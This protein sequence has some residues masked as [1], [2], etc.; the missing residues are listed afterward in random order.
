[1][2]C[3]AKMSTENLMEMMRRSEKTKRKKE[4]NE[5]ALRCEC[6]HKTNH[7]KKDCW[8][9]NPLLKP[10]N[11]GRRTGT[12]APKNFK[13]RTCYACG[14]PGHVAKYCRSKKIG[15]GNSAFFGFATIEETNVQ[16]EEYVDSGATKHIAPQV[17]DFVPGSLKKVDS[18]GVRQADG[19][20]L[21]AT[22]VGTRTI[23]HKDGR[24]LTLKEVYLVP[25]LAIKLISVDAL[26]KSGYTVTFS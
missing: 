10:R 13:T 22:H 24:T 12:A 20:L 2:F 19:S 7:T 26:T 9:N 15:D 17:T 16:D 3:G 14:K 5:T 4:M 11:Y 21:K 1:M 8:I 18:Q 6:C 25:K 23:K